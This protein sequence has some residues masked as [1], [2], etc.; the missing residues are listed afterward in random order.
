MARRRS[1][2][3]PSPTRN[4]NPVRTLY[5]PQIVRRIVKRPV[6]RTVIKTVAVPR[7]NP[8][9]Q[10]VEDRRRWHPLR[11]L[12]PAQT[13]NSRASRRLVEKPRITRDPFPSLR[14]GF[15]VPS[16]VA[17]CVRRKSRREVLFAIK[18]TGAGAR[19]KRRRRNQLSN[20]QC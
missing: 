6:Y 2:L 14:L 16:K 13:L 10:Q 15:A 18:G 20:L 11:A 19:Q 4:L 17:A 1:P 3:P 7:P 12:A 9:L 8:P 5:E